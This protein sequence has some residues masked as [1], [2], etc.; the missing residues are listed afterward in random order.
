MLYKIGF[1]TI[2]EVCYPVIHYKNI[3]FY[4]YFFLI[5]DY[6]SRYNKFDFK[7]SKYYFYKSGELQKGEFR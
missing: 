5:E 6:Y 3:N 7:K 2:E 1:T 4:H